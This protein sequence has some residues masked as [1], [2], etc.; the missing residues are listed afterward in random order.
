MSRTESSSTAKP[1]GLARVTAAWACLV[2]PI[3]PSAIDA[4]TP[5]SRA[6]AGPERLGVIALMKSVR[7]EHGWNECIRRVQRVF[8]KKGKTAPLEFD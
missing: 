6:S 8:P 2:R 4:I 5:S 7:T 1:Y 3:M